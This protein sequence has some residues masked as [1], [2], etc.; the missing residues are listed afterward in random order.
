M[1]YARITSRPTS[2][3]AQSF[4]PSQNNCMSA[5][6]AVKLHPATANTFTTNAAKSHSHF[7]KYRAGSSMIGSSNHNSP[8]KT[9]KVF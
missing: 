9:D 5:N 1:S 4:N 7:F 8:T 3:A 2:I 6:W